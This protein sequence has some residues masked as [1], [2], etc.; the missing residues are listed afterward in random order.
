MNEQR[1]L[2]KLRFV[3][4]LALCL[5]A[6]AFMPQVLM[7]PNSGFFY[8]GVAIPFITGVFLRSVIVGLFFLAA[9]IYRWGFVWTL[10]LGYAYWG[11]A[12]L[13]FDFASAVAW[14][15]NILANFWLLLYYGQSL[16]ALFLRIVILPT[17][18]ATTFIFKLYKI[19]PVS[20]ALLVIWLSLMVGGAAVLPH[21][22]L[23]GERYIPETVLPQLY[24]FIALV[25]SF[26][27][28]FSFFRP[29]R[30]KTL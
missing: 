18:T 19:T 8:G 22:S 1:P 6:L 7:Y 24:E 12:G 14:G 21:D 16:L 5:L 2:P 27:F 26:A 13:V 10:I 9:W 23:L 3:T 11:F 15:G 4:S 25:V 17:A 29:Y 30:G 20:L 28:A